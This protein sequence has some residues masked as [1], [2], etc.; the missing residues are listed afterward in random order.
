MQ[1]IC[2]DAIFQANPKYTHDQ[3]VKRIF[4]YLKGTQEFGLWYKR[5]GDF[6]LEAYT[7][8]DWAKSI[9]DRKSTSSGELF[10]GDRLV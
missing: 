4:R 9:D 5:D 7:Y 2:L 8:A 1:A 10:L 3:V 6:M